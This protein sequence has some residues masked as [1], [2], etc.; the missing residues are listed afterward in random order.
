MG[1][2]LGQDLLHLPYLPPLPRPGPPQPPTNPRPLSYNTRTITIGTLQMSVR[3]EEEDQSADSLE[4]LEKLEEI[5]E[6]DLLSLEALR[7][8]IS[9]IPSA[10][11]IQN[12][13]FFHDA[14]NNAKVSLEIIEFLLETFPGAADA[15]VQYGDD[16]DGATVAYPLHLACR[17]EK[18]PNSVIELLMKKNTYALGHMCLVYN[19]VPSGGLYYVRGVPGY[20]EGTP[21]HYYLS[22]KSNIDIDVVRML[23]EVYPDALTTADDESKCTPLH[24]LVCNPNIAH[25]CDVLQFIVETEPDSLR[26]IGGYDEVPLHLACKN[27]NSSSKV[28]QMLLDYWPESTY[29]RS[30][31]GDLP[32]HYFC[33]NSTSPY[34]ANLPNMTC[35]SSI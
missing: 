12:S 33:S 31:L 22:R 5:C 13:Y 23:V 1:R 20:V 16:A 2:I 21:L 9:S 28:V 30:R 17:N 10:D 25:L 27:S 19:G 14:C 3:E 4:K 34:L 18:C 11:A 6:T 8:I 29:Q 35:S 15:T 26:M 24:T 32:I 7:N